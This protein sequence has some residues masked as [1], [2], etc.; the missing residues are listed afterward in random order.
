[1][2]TRRASVVEKAVEC[3]LFSGVLEQRLM[4]H[5]HVPSMLQRLILRE[6][7]TVLLWEL[8]FDLKNAR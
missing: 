3:V 8:V 5:D 1:M 7:I 6:V 4:Q 2:W